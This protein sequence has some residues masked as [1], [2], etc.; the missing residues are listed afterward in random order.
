MLKK[1]AS[2][3][4]MLSASL[5]LNACETAAYR[6]I[7]CEPGTALKDG[8]CQKVPRIVK[9]P[10]PSRPATAKASPGIMSTLDQRT[11]RVKQNVYG[12]PL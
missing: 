2:L 3:A 6:P 10:T 1:I 4:A 7:I 9:K 11:P 12:Q 5:T 8:R